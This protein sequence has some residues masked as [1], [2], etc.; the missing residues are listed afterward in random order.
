MGEWALVCEGSELNL[1]CVA[2]TTWVLVDRAEQLGVELQPSGSNAPQDFNRP[3]AAERELAL[4]FRRRWDAA[5]G[6]I[7]PVEHLTPTEMVAKVC[8]SEC[9]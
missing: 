9:V 3:D 5:L 1:N 7:K 8:H 4:L 2:P 6:K